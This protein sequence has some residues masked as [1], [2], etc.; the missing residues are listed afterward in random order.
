MKLYTMTAALLLLPTVSAAQ[1]NDRT[2]Q[3][4]KMG[5]P[6]SQIP[7]CTKEYSIWVLKAPADLCREPEGKEENAMRRVDVQR[8]D[9]KL[10]RRLYVLV[11]GEDSHVI[12][13]GTTHDIDDAEQMY[14]GVVE[15]RGTASGRDAQSVQT[16][17]GI[18][19]KR[20]RAHWQTSWGEIHLNA[21]GSQTDEVDLFA[22][23]SE[24]MKLK[25]LSA[26]KQKASNQNSY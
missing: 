13:V 10:T 20:Y 3:G 18:S 6:V 26:R 23:T 11:T 7:E 9:G 22:F 8:R 24:Y 4:M 25:T 16:G 15:K 17:L 5:T 2:F 1:R 21:P 12:Y 19:A 14:K